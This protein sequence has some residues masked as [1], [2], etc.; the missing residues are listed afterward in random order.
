M[1]TKKQLKKQLQEEKR[2]RKYAERDAKMWCDVVLEQEDDLQR[3]DIIIADMGQES[4]EKQ[5]ELKSA[6]AISYTFQKR[7]I[8]L[9]AEL[10]EYKSEAE[11][12]E[13]QLTELEA[14]KAWINGEPVKIDSNCDELENTS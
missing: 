13:R 12:L 2:Q 9:E 14:P 1:M 11:S 7:N 8:E 10:R 6:L 5:R 4:R 3:K